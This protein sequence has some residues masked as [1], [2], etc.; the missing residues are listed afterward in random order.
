MICRSCQ[1]TTNHRILSLRSMPLVNRLLDHQYDTCASHSLEV[2]YCDACSL[3]QLKEIVPPMEMFSEYSFYSSVM[4]P[5]VDRAE[6]L[7]G[8]VIAEKRPRFVIEVGSNDGYLLHFYR[9]TGVPVLGVDVARGPANEAA[10]KGVP[11]VQELFSLQVAKTLPKADVVHANN[12]LAHCPDVND[13]VAGFA[14]VLNPGGTVIVEVPY[15]GDLVSQATFDTV[16]HEHIFYFS[17]KSLVMLFERHGLNIRRIEPMPD[18][19]GGSLRIFACNTSHKCPWKDTGLEEISQLQARTDEYAKNLKDALVRLRDKGRTVWGFGAAAKATVFLN[20]AGIDQDLIEA[21]ADD[22]PAKQ[23]KFIPGTG[24]PIRSTQDWLMSQPQHTCIF[25]WNY[26][27]Y[28]AH[29]YALTYKGN[30]FTSRLPGLL[31]L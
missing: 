19:L 26:A 18:V 20:Y 3:G 9:K 5:I 8:S 7:V 10:L 17:I 13:V 31:V 23:Y 24:I 4:A 30:F 16:Y 28:I 12:V 21:V 2:M 22:T 25:T 15:L 14:E 27:H 1:A 11:T 29:K 6:K